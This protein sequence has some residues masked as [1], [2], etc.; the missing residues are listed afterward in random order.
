MPHDIGDLGPISVT[1]EA[2]SQLAVIQEDLVNESGELSTLFLLL[3]LR[4]IRDGDTSRGLCSRQR[5][6]PATRARASA[7]LQ[8]QSA[9]L[10]LGVLQGA[11]KMVPKGWPAAALHHL[12]SPLLDHALEPRDAGW[13]LLQQSDLDS[14]PSVPTAWQFPCLQAAHE[15]LTS[16]SAVEERELQFAPGAGQGSPITARVFGGAAGGAG[17]WLTRPCS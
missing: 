4:G 5:S 10:H 16:L 11:D 9:L 17:M 6:M 1:K 3:F 14:R 12:A 13:D 2:A 15:Q 7:H 8:L